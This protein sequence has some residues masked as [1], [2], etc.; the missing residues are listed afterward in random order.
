MNEH[1]STETKDLFTALA[2]AQSEIETANKTNDNLFFKSRY[3]D[4]A[5]IVNSSRAVLTKHGLSVS[6]VIDFDEVSQMLISILAHSSGQFIRSRVR[7]QP[8]K[9]DIQTFG[10]YITYL[11]R[12]SYAALVGVVVCD[13]DDDGEAAMKHYR[14]EPTTDSNRITEQ[15]CQALD[16]LIGTNSNLYESFLKKGGISSLPE[17]PASRFKDALDWTKQQKQKE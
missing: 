12:Y 1:T 14:E 15:Q 10:S 17:L 16:E 4:L 5:E 3:A 8:P 11:R 9:S 7:I 6:Q 2:L 13:E